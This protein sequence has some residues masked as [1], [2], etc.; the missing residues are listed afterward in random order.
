MR[1]ATGGA[2]PKEACLVHGTE[3][4]LPSGLGAGACK[5]GADVSLLRGIAV[6]G[7]GLPLRAGS[8]HQ[9]GSCGA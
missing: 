4:R 2:G 3:G 7:R 1:E 8:G 5:S 9:G 6:R